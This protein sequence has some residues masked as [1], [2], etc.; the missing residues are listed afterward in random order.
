MKRIPDRLRRTLAALA[1]VLLAAGFAAAQDDAF[2]KLEAIDYSKQ[3]VGREQ[4]QDLELWNL[5]MLRG[6]VFGRHG[7]I[8]KDRDIQAY[9]KDKPWYK[10]DPNFTNSALNATER[11]NLD[12]IRELEAEKHDQIDRL[13]RFQAAHADESVPMLERLR[14]AALDGDNIF[15]VLMDAVR[16]CSLGQITDTLF[17]VGGRYRR[18]V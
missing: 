9:L 15:A 6:V 17:E 1:L 5:Q 7:R 3:K 2:K 11:A 13:R 4:L 8:F 18:N 12:V 14:Q 16:C 10:P